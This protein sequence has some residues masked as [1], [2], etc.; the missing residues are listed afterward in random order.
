MHMDF[1][2]VVYLLT[3]SFWIVFEIHEVLGKYKNGS[4]QKFV[5]V[6]KIKRE[7]NIEISF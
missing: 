4:V 3:I 5:L 6:L 2:C 1:G 7:V